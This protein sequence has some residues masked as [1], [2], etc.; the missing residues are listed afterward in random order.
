VP[1]LLVPALLLA[2]CGSS[3]TV[4]TPGPTT[5]LSTVHR[6]VARTE[7]AGT[8]HLVQSTLTRSTLGGTSTEP[9]SGTS[10]SVVGDIRFAGPDLSATTTS[11]SMLPSPSSGS[12]PGPQSSSTTTTS[13][14][15]WLGPHLYQE[16]PPGPV[17]TELPVRT[18]ISF[19]GI[20]PTHFL[21]TAPGPVT[22]VGHREI[23]GQVTTEYLVPVPRSEHDVPL[24]DSH[25]H[26]Y[27]ARFTTD[28]FTLAVWLDGAGRIVRTSGSE[29]VTS[30]RP[31]GKERQTTTVT[32]SAFGEPVHIVA[33][34]VTQ[35]G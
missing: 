18:P 3:G 21:E 13:R 9:V 23:D 19:L 34:T 31:S 8:A 1:A 2:A 33:P 26:P 20:V 6:A 30:P 17:W 15:V 7:A 29:V 24:T 28:P 27:T 32:L 4:A 5:A 25:D 35:P 10:L 22:D 16:V 11:R 14:S 12:V